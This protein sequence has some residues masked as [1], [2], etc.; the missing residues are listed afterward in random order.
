MRKRGKRR[1]KDE[2]SSPGISEL[3]GKKVPQCTPSSHSKGFTPSFEPLVFVAPENCRN[4]SSSQFFALVE[5]ALRN[6]PVDTGPRKTETMRRRIERFLSDQHRKEL[7]EG[8]VGAGF[9]YMIGVAGSGKSFQLQRF[10]N[11]VDLR[12]PKGA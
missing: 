6:F 5:H 12:S 9:L 1:P 11:R 7:W 8:H 10:A 4:L 3:R 2:I